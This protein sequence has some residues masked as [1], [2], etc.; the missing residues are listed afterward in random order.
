MPQISQARKLKA[1]ME[2]AKKSPTL[3]KH[4]EEEF[5]ELV[6]YI[7]QITLKTE[8]AFKGSNTLDVKDIIKSLIKISDITSD[9]QWNLRI[10]CLK[11]IRK[12][13]ELENKREYLP[14]FDWGDNWIDFKEQ[15]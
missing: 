10:I 6:V 7:I 4:F 15:I 1:Y 13:V 8:D 12:V 14:A 2:S 5:E 9:I 3:H 11:V